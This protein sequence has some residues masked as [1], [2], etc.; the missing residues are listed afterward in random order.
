M[1]FEKEE[2]A[3]SVISLGNKILQLDKQIAELKAEIAR[4]KEHTWCAYCGLEIHIDDAAATK[5]SEHIMACEKHPIHIALAD[6]LRQA[7]E[8]NTLIN[9]AVDIRLKLNDEIAH[10]AEEIK[11]LTSLLLQ[12]ERKP[13]ST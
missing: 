11:R 12:F 5:I 6:N 1:N 2:H 8:I 10:Q 3:K 13:I 9:S 4:M 7:E